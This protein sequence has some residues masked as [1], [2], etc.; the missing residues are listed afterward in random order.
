MRIGAA[1]VCLT[2]ASAEFVC[3]GVITGVATG[4]AG[5]AG[6]LCANTASVVIPKTMEEA[7][8]ALWNR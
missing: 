5:V 4:L 6:G 1:G 7:K 3:V 8:M 2:T